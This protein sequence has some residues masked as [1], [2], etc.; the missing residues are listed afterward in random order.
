MTR[1]ER[2]AR[3]SILCRTASRPL[4]RATSLSSANLSESPSMTIPNSRC[5]L[6]RDL[7][8]PRDYVYTLERRHLRA[9]LPKRVDLRPGCPQVFNQGGI[10]TCTA[11]AVAAA[12][13]YERRLQGTRA[14]V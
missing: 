3:P 12:V 4:R 5:T 6:A 8:D 10:G 14:M 9:P 7:P 2:C 1:L 11:H 13:A